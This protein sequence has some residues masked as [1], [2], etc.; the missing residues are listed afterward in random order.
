MSQTDFNLLSQPLLQASPA[1]WVSLPG[2]L[3]CLV[4]DEIETFPALRPHQAPAWHMFLVQLAALGLHR[5]RMN[6]L[7]ITEA[8]WVQV[9]RGLT[10]EFPE[11]E[12]WCLVVEDWGRPAF[13][14]PPVPTAITLKTEVSTPDGLDLLITSR[15]HDLKQEVARKAQIQDWVLALIS[16]QTSE[17]YGGAGNQGIT[18]MNGGHSSRPL[19]GFAPL[20]QQNGKVGTPRPGAWFRR[21]VIVL[22]ATR[23]E[24]WSKQSF[25][26]FPADG[27]LGLTWVVPWEDGQQL[28]LEQLDLWF[29]EICRRVRL[30][31][32][33]NQLCAQSGNSSAPRLFA[34]HLNGAV[35]DPWAPVHVTAGKGFTLAGRNFDYSTLVDVLFSGDWKMP[36]LA[37]QSALESSAE[38]MALVTAALSRGNCKTEGFKSRILPLAVRSLAQSA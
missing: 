28:G 27:G 26:G 3:A 5:V 7:P 4:R 34:K 33:E 18:R 24:E 23:D 10:P 12:P 38:T 1:G 35:G 30:K 21:D 37:R 11:D 22:L 20:S 17:G 31:L 14:Q 16:L 9:L 15:N 32:Q 29:I 8:E 19:V 13:L 25:L 6:H 2:L 36:L